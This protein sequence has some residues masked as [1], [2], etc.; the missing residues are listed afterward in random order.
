MDVK[1]NN[2]DEELTNMISQGKKID[3]INYISEEND[4]IYARNQNKILPFVKK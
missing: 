2:R 1:G 3:S 4:K